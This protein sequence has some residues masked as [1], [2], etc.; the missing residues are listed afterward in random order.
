VSDSNSIALLKR[1]SLIVRHSPERQ[2]S[3]QW[4]L[5]SLGPWFFALSLANQV[6][7]VGSR[8]PDNLTPTNQQRG[9]LVYPLLQIDFAGNF[10]PITFYTPPLRGSEARR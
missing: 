6:L 2:P 10:V 3:E 4:R 1:T 5:V 9:V 8:L 7:A